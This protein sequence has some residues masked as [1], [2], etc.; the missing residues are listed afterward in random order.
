ML[1]MPQILQIKV[2]VEALENLQGLCLGLKRPRGW[3]SNPEKDALLWKTWAQ[4]PERDHIFIYLNSTGPDTTIPVFILL[5]DQIKSSPQSHIC[6][7][8][9]DGI[10]M[11]FL[12]VCWW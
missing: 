9:K 12:F 5:H 4:C 1:A 2:A 11:T 3:K 10:I 7:D 6:G 8:M